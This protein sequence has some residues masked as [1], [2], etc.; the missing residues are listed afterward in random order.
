MNKKKILNLPLTYEKTDFSDER[1]T[2]VRVKVMHSGL[3]LNGS[4]FT[5]AAIGK[6]A[7]SLKN[8]PLL[9]FVKKSDGTDEADF[10][11]HEFEFKVTEDGVKYIYLGRPIGM[12][13]E[14]NNYSY[15]EDEEGV[16]FVSVDA[17]IWNDYA[18]EA[19]DIVHRDGGK[20]VS[21]EVG[22][23]DFSVEDE[24]GV[25]DI[26]DYLYNGVVLL[27]DEVAPAMRNARLDIAEFSISG[28]SEFVA[29]FSRDLQETINERDKKFTETPVDS[30]PETDSSSEGNGDSDSAPTGTDSAPAEPSGPSEKKVEATVSDTDGSEETGAPEESPVSVEPEKASE[31]EEKAKVDEP[32]ADEPTLENPIVD[33]PTAEENP[34][35]NPPTVTV[36]EEGVTIRKFEDELE[37]LRTKNEILE[38][39]LETLRAFKADVEKK[40]FDQKVATLVETFSDLPKEDVNE[41]IKTETD[42]EIIELKLYA[43]RGRL[44][45]ETPANRIQAFAIYDSGI[46]QQAPSWEKLVEAHINKTTKGGN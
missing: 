19:L 31:E 4:R 22:V 28:I 39:E 14:T 40:E 6:A 24:T 33:E 10:A 44:N 26:H 30:N 17:Y 21:M 3:N 36:T 1:F 46:T 27:G 38:T 43:L 23:Q 25:L 7:P 15:E 34:P 35:Y 2:K 9:A 32:I 41:I 45:S 37:D 13:P 16:K 11:G 8:I 18:N 42:Y 20:S 29:N 5:D 12:I